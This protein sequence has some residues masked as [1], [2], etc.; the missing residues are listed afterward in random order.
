MYITYWNPPKTRQISFEEILAGVNN[1]ESLRC[2]GDKTS[3]MTVSRSDLTPR[4]KM[5]TD[6]PKMIEQL[7]EF[8]RKYSELESNPLD[9]Y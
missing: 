3:T 2:G 8:N 5:I 4:L 1:V 6:I 9:L 7:A